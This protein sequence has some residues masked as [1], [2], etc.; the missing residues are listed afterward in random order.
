MKRLVAAA[1]FIGLS[2]PALAQNECQSL[3]FDQWL[4]QFG[5]EA[6]ASGVPADVVQSALSGVS[7]SQ[8]IVNRDRGQA[9]FGQDFLTFSDRMANSNRRQTG[10][11]MLQRH[12]S[13]FQQVEATYGVPGAVI[14]S[15]WGLETD[16]GGFLG[17]FP[18]LTSVATLAYD[19]RRPEM[20]RGHFLSALQI[21]ARGDLQP[22]EMRGAWA[23]EVGQ[24]QFMMTDYLRNGVDGDGDGRVDMLRSIPDVVASA[25]NLLLHHGWQA[26]QPWLEEV[27]VPQNLPWHEAD[28]TIKHTRAD[29]AAAGV[30]Y[31]SGAAIPADGLPAS[32]VLPMGHL[33]PAFLAYPNFD[34]YLQ[35]NQSLVY[36]TTAAYL[37]TRIAGA[38]AMQRGSAQPLS[39]EQVVAVQRALQARGYDVG[40]PDGIIGALTRAAVR[41]QQ[42][43]LGLPADGYPDAA[44]LQALR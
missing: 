6:V 11:S 30:S 16:F 20:F 2:S 15:F 44:L 41:D 1:L 9:V 33:G 5:Q 21:I 17:D 19:C 34:V 10:Q 3:P 28:V 4:Q 32:L 18:T 40:Q 7:F 31:A 43:Q 24:V 12:S 27:R 38:P 39:G 42:Q 8:E 29:W 36:S 13:L 14:A 37:A 35:W 25:A 23:G 26:G 22:S